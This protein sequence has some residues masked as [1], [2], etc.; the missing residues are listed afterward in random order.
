MLLSYTDEGRDEGKWVHIFDGMFI[1]VLIFLVG[2]K[3]SILLFD[4]E[5][6]RSLR[7]L[8]LAN[9]ARFEVFVN[10]LLAGVHFFQIHGVSL[11][12]LRN[13]GVF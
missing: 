7:Q 4:K 10:E 12:H 11:G 1:E 2:M 9:F 3:S 6:G 5:E 13:E 8:G